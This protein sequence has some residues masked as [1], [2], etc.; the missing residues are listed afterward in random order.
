MPD[1]NA[2]NWSAALAGKF[3]V[4][5]G[6]DGSGKTTQLRRVVEC[7][8]AAGVELIEVREPGGTHIGEHIREVLLDKETGELA[9][10]CEML[11]YMASRAQLVEEK[12]LPALAKNKLVIADRFVSSTLAYQGAAGGLPQDEIRAVAACALQGLRPDLV[13]IFDVDEVTAAA[14]MN[15]LLHAQNGGAPTRDRAELDRIE[16]RG[17]EFHRKVRA[18]YLEQA[19]LDPEHHLVVDASKAPEQVWEELKRGLCER[20]GKSGG[21][22]SG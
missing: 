11:L 13:I 9:M 21:Q 15:P 4:F 3:L 6:P 5:E 10:R 2:H 12:I 1:A 20:F 17:L 7:C 18:G 22:P 16:A 8:K 19:R 14:R